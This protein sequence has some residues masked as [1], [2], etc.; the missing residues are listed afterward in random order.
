ML[1][2]I[3]IKNYALIHEMEVSFDG[4]FS[5]VTGETG[6]G[7]SIILG[8][9]GLTLGDR[10]DT[11]VLAD[12]KV[13]CVVETWFAISNLSLEYFFEKNGLDYEEETI[14]RRE[15]LPSG[16]SRAFINDTPVSLSILKLLSE[17]LID[18]H[19]QHQTLLLNNNQ[20]QLKLIDTN[21]GNHLLFNSYKLAFEKYKKTEKELEELLDKESRLKVDQDYFQFQ[22][23]ELDKMGLEGVK[24]EEIKE[25]LEL[26]TNSEEIKTHLT[27]SIS[28]LENDLG[29]MYQLK[30]I[31]SL[32]SKIAGS[33]KTIGE[34]HAR[35][36]SLLIELEDILS[37]LE[38]TNENIVFDQE[39]INDLSGLLDALNNLHLKHR[40]QSIEELIEVK[41]KL[42]KNL[43]LVTGFDSEKIKLQENKKIALEELI[44]Q[45]ALLSTSRKK[46]IPII[47]KEVKLMLQELSLEHAELRIEIKESPNF[48][49][50]GKDQLNFLF[51][52][53]K[54]SAFNLISKVAS[55]GELSR[56]MLS[57][58]TNLASKKQLPTLI[59]DEIDTGVSGDIASKMGEMMKR[60]GGTSQVISITHLPQIA[61]KGNSHYKVFKKESEETTTTQMVKLDYQSRVVE[62]AKMLSGASIS[63]AALENAKSL[64]AN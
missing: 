25:E 24:E 31:E 61:S 30:S 50:Y 11:K 57:I 26:L 33:G 40:T 35:F 45:G 32:L 20:F 46:V 1:S 38:S 62:L 5:C 60:I 58:K 13:K 48:G 47:E 63:D 39:R 43:L 2:K 53:N 54:G 23:D 15:I 56:L 44:Q 42:E 18:V 8:A 41:S 4:G 28:I 7:K 16:K 37:D 19:S 10:V 27:Q 36:A 34:L 21:A 14:L 52:A 3:K 29:G 64:L 12:N 55:G 22:F 49:E 9:L 51:R 59:F 17:K 6:A